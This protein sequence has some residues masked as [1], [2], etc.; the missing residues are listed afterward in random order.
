MRRGLRPETTLTDVSKAFDR[1]CIKLY[2]RKLVD[3]G[4]PRQL[5]ESV[6]KFLSGLRV[7]LSWG[8]VVTC[9][10]QRG[11]YGVPQGSLEGMLNFSVYSD[12]IQRS[13]I[14]SVPGILVGGQVVRIV[15]YADDDSPI[16]SCPRLTNL[17]LDAIASQGLY[18]CFKFK[19]AK[20]SDRLESC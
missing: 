18:N 20:C 12:N 15:V 7:H 9:A 17:A 6:V 14:K 16:N 1:L 5:I 10:I 4:L 8:D 19:P 13:I 3:Y 2:V 11:D